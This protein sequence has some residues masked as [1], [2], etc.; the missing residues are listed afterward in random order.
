[1]AGWYVTEGIDGSNIWDGDRP[2]GAV[3]KDVASRM[4]AAPD[5]LAALEQV[6]ANHLVDPYRTT[7]DVLALVD[8]ALAKARGE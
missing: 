5:L 7:D 1:M 8:A 3:N 4:A 6:Q 2:I